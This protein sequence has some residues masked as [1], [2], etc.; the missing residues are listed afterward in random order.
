MIEENI[1]Q[2]PRPAPARRRQPGVRP[3]RPRPSAEGGDTLLHRPHRRGRRRARSRSSSTGGPR[4]PSPSTGPPAASRWAWPAAATSPPAAASCLGI[5][6]ELFGD[7]LASLGVGR[8]VG[9]ARGHRPGRADRRPRDRPHRPAQRH[10]RHHPGRAGRDHPGRRCPACSSC[11]AGP[12][13]ARPSWPCTAPPTCSTRT[14]SRSRA[15]ACSSSAPTG[16][17][18][19]TSSRC[20]PSLGEAGVEL[21][22]LADLVAR[23]QR[24]AAYDRR[25][26]RPGQG[27]PPHGRGPGQ[28]RPRPR[29]AAAP[30]PAASATASR[31]LQPQ[32]RARA[33]RIV[34]DARRRF[35]R[36]NAGRRFV[37]GERLRR[38]S[39]TV[40][41]D[42]RRR[43]TRCASASARP[44]RGARGPRAD[45]AGAHARPAPPRPLR[46][47]R[48]CCASPAA[49]LPRRR[50]AAVAATGRA[51]DVA[52]R[53]RL[54]PRRRAR[55]STRPGR[56][57]A[58]SRGAG[59]PA[60][61]SRRRDPHLRP[62]RRRRGPGPLADAAADARRAARSTAR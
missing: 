37:E 28:G 44:A 50:R 23:R 4:W 11:R 60:R 19:A 55:C 24:R 40:G 20:C 27:R 29:A 52:R 31:R 35:R 48:R 49:T 33:R 30:R 5:E 38:R 47:A 59:A 25:P 7:T 16:C 53:G 58:R 34:A 61:P 9:R 18:S 12:A 22:V 62:H 56:C 51:S 32:P 46:L 45:V 54:D 39:P 43:P 57:S 3:H 41:R 10:R 14:G 15:R 21:A 2:P 13:P 36:H 26:H 6:D 8:R 42:D 1:V 17:S